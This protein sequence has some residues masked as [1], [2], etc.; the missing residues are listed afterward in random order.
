MQSPLCIHI[1]DD[2]SAGGTFKALGVMTQWG[3]FIFAIFKPMF[4]FARPAAVLCF[5]E[6]EGVSAGNQASTAR[7]CPRSVL[8]LD[9][10]SL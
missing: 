10:P 8:N 7:F 6:G 2:I 1:G 5:Y 9:M 4:I 3:A